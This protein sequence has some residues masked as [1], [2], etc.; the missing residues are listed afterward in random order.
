LVAIP[1]HVILGIWDVLMPSKETTHRISTQMLEPSDSTKPGFE[2]H[3]PAISL[4]VPVKNGESLLLANFAEI[5]RE[6]EN[7]EISFEIIYVD[8]GSTDHSKMIMSGLAQ[9]Y[10]YVKALFVTSPATSSHPFDSLSSCLRYGVKL[11][12]Y[13]V[14]VFPGITKSFSM[15]ELKTHLIALEKG[16]SLVFYRP[17]LGIGSALVSLLSTTFLSVFLRRRIRITPKEFEATGWISKKEILSGHLHLPFIDRLLPFYFRLQGLHILEKNKS[18]QDESNQHEPIE[19]NSAQF[20]PNQ[21]P[22]HMRH[23]IKKRQA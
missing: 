21:T 1:P 2:S 12:R 6:L 20:K 19:H 22:Q 15:K 14:I 23:E 17:S 11:A 9:N 13:E 7:S 18:V 5:T 16:Y 10:S 8:Y 3:L 4:I